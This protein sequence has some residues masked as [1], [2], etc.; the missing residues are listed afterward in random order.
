MAHDLFKQRILPMTDRL[1]RLAFCLLHSQQEAEDVVQDAMIRIWS[2]QDEWINW[3]NPEGY[4]M[5]TV[6]NLCIDKTRK[7]GIKTLG[8]DEVL[9]PGKDPFEEMDRKETM[10]RIRASIQALPEQ[11]Q[12]IIHLREI[13]GFS[14]N[15]IAGILGQSLDQVKVNL[16]R[17]R[18]ALKKLVK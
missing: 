11:Q 2:K 13:E 6:R 4:C 3:E 12:V 9:S 17:A 14:Y 16:F 8:E 10:G 15:E 5:R 1:F 7:K 18:N